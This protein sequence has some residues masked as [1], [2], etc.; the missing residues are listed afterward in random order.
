MESVLPSG[1][2]DSVRCAP[3]SVRCTRPATKR[4][5]HSR[6]FSRRAPLKFTGLSGVH[7]TCPVSQRSNGHYAQWSTAKANSEVNSACRSHSREVRAHRTCPVCHRTVRCNYRKRLQRST[8]S[9]PQWACWCGAHRTV[10]STCPVRH[11]TVRCAHCQQT[12]PTAR[13][14][15]EAINT[16]NH[17]LQWHPSFLKFPFNTRAIAFTTRHIPK[18][19]SSP[20]P[21]INSTT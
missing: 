19:K 12:Q 4:T 11:R 7:R 15:L 3:D 14:W 17:L 13:K 10:N 2:P 18:I 20:S 16:P 5:S 8:R 9:K 21:K 1:A 6:E